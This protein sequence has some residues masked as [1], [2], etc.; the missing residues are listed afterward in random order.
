M[1]FAHSE[2]ILDRILKKSLQVIHT[3]RFERFGRRVEFGGIR[4]LEQVHQVAA[5]VGSQG[6][7]GFNQVFLAVFIRN[8]MP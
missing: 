1:R 6:V 8:K 3:R 5:T 2:E 7:E 4:A